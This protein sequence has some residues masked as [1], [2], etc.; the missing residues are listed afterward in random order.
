[1]ALATPAAPLAGRLLSMAW[2]GG[3]AEQILDRA[4]VMASDQLSQRRALVREKVSENSWRWLPKWVD[5]LL[6]DKITDGLVRTLEEMR[7]P[8]HPWRLELKEAVERYVD[9]LASDPATMA[10]GEAMKR[11]LLDDAAFH[12]HLRAIWSDLER[13]LAADPEEAA[14]ITRAAVERAL[15]ATRRWLAS[16]PTARERLNGFVRVAVRR[17]LTPRREAIGAFVADV[18]A[19]WD[20]K[21]VVDRLELHVGRDLQAIRINGALVGAFAGLIIFAVAKALS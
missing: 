20:A 18:V 6:A 1:M 15:I 3:A 9:R 13:R 11:R 12:G 21:A 10:R 4:L 17:T 14:R 7:D 8:A 5:R 19:G 2:S 16:D